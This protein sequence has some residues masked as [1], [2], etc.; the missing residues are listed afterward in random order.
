MPCS[1]FPT[2]SIR[3]KVQGRLGNFVLET[4]G[5][6]SGSW[7]QGLRNGCYIYERSQQ[8]RGLNRKTGAQWEKAGGVDTQ[9]RGSQMQ[10]PRDQTVKR[11][12]SRSEHSGCLWKPVTSGTGQGLRLLS[13]FYKILLFIIFFSE[14][15]ATSDN[16]GVKV[17]QT[18]PC[19]CFI[20][21]PEAGIQP[22]QTFYL[23]TFSTLTG[24]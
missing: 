9:V 22:Q 23:F 24:K 8:D 5:N 12:P 7:E 18:Q 21:H 11:K 17:H 3:P 6:F 10:D 14:I 2:R 16:A 20:S 19:Y 13:F 1:Y 4:S 15:Q